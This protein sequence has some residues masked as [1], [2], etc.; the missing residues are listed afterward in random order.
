MELLDKS[1]QAIKEIADPR[2]ILLP[3]TLAWIGKD[4]T[5]V[6]IKKKPA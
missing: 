1:D 3:T 6:R 5:K 2:M 4:I